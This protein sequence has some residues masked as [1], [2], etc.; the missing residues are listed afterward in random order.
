[1]IN[2]KIKI[3]W[4]KTDEEKIQAARMA[5]NS[6]QLEIQDNPFLEFFRKFSNNSN[7][8]LKKVNSNLI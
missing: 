4:A 8:L 5:K 1:M 2:D 3:E 6:R 7:N